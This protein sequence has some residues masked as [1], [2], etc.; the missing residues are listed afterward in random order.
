MGCSGD[1]TLRVLSRLIDCDLRGTVALCADAQAYLAAMHSPAHPCDFWLLRL[2][3]LPC[4]P[5]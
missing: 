3:K 4:L 1:T 2:S 5:A